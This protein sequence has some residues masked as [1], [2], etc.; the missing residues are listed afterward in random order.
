MN[1]NTVSAYRRYFLSKKI[2]NGSIL[3]SKEKN[4]SNS[5]SSHSALRVLD[6]LFGR[7]RDSVCNSPGCEETRSPMIRLSSELAPTH[8]KY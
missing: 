5:S 7:D 6:S 4:G 1:K 8:S 2:S 3:Q